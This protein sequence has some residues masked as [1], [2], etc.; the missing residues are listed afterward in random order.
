[1]KS[2]V[3]KP[4]SISA[5]R[6]GLL[7]LPEN[8]KMTS[9]YSC[10]APSCFFTNPSLFDTMAA[11]VGVESSISCDLRSSADMPLVRLS[12]S[13]ASTLACFLS[14]SSLQVPYMQHKNEMTRAEPMTMNTK[15]F[16]KTVARSS[17]AATANVAPYVAKAE[18]T[19][20]PMSM[21][22]VPP[23]SSSTL[24]VSGTSSDCIRRLL[25]RCSRRLP[26]K[27]SCILLFDSLGLSYSVIPPST[28]HLHVVFVAVYE[29]TT[30]LSSLHGPSPPEVA[31]P[32]VVTIKLPH[33]SSYSR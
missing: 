2:K 10:F 23:T 21:L 31:Q 16:F 7:L 3:K 11:N 25:P 15:I 5:T 4:V 24:G 29:I 27:I 6:C 28:S 30:Q 26:V 14:L 19:K 22:L 12:F 17:V 9:A 18:P 8:S 33:G 20:P 32:G 1:M 13:S